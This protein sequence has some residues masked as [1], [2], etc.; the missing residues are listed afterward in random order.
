MK[1]LL[2]ILCLALLAALI[3]EH[4]LLTASRHEVTALM[5][6]LDATRADLRGE[7][8]SCDEYVAKHAKKPLCA[9][10][11]KPTWSEGEWT[12]PAVIKQE[13]K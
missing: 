13:A 7:V 4:E 11:Q 10:D 12:C 5:S 9:Q 6:V 3:G 2:F 8:D 1:T